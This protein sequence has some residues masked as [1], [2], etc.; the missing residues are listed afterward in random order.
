MIFGRMSAAGL[1]GNS[2]KRSVGLKEITYLGYV[3]T[4]EVIKH[5]L[6]KVQEILY[7]KQQNTTTEER[8]LTDIVRYYRDMWH[9]Q[10]HV[11][12]PP[13]E[14]SRDLKGRK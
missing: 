4:R 2:P 10:S 14:A 9:R 8:S 1:K 12:A 3:I 11:L 13:T 6:K 5:D 7:L